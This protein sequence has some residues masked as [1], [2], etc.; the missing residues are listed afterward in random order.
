MSLLD[1]EMTG[2]VTGGA[3][4]VDRSSCPHDLESRVGQ[5]GIERGLSAQNRRRIGDEAAG[6]P[7]YPVR[8]EEGPAPVQRP[9]PLDGED[10]VV[11]HV[12][13][14]SHAVGSLD[15]PG[16]DDRG[17]HPLAAVSDLR[18]E[19]SLGV[20]NHPGRGRTRSRGEDSASGYPLGEALVLQLG[21]R[22][23]NRRPRQAEL[24]AQLVLAGELLTHRDGPGGDALGEDDEQLVVVG[25]R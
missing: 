23:T 20:L 5:G 13:G 8:G 6:R 2:H 10:L 15:E 4:P 11:R 24:L 12:Q 1:P 25:R 18:V 9:H 3:E 17:G 22:L 19:E 14:L 16:V 21:E 7:G